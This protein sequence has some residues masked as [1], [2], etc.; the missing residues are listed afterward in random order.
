[1]D[2][3]RAY[4]MRVTQEFVWQLRIARSECPLC[5]KLGGCRWLE[6]EGIGHV[7]KD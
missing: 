3:V 2:D 4:A 5:G 6:C 1:M 7:A